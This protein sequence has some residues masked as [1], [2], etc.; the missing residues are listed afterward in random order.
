MYRPIILLAGIG[1]IAMGSCSK[2]EDTFLRFDIDETYEMT[3]PIIPF[4]SIE[5]P[6]PTPDVTST[7][8]QAFE[9]NS[10]RADKVRDIRLT[11]LKFTIVDPPD[12]DFSFMKDVE[13]YLAAQG[14]ETT[15]MAF[16]YNISEDVGA[17]LE[18]ETSEENLDKFK[19]IGSYNFVVNV[20]TRTSVDQPIN[21]KADMTFKVTADVF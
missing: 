11:K 3:I 17:V 7:F 19:N 8:D 13:L 1:I 6:V 18:L 9:A 21:V 10:T 12:E 15:L 16:K 2:I 5:A 4:D 14:V 20:V